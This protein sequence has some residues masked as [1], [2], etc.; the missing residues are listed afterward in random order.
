[1]TRLPP[2]C[3][4]LCVYFVAMQYNATIFHSAYCCVHIRDVLCN[5]FFSVFGELRRYDEVGN[6][7]SLNKA[8]MRLPL[9]TYP[10]SVD[11]M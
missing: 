8:M 5:R 7:A 6:Q 1:M 2:Y 3:T 11:M 9:R 4:G 10:D